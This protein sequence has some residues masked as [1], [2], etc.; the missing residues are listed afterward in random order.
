MVKS[1]KKKHCIRI[2]IK[3]KTTKYFR[4][5]T[6]KSELVLGRLLCLE[7]SSSKK[8]NLPV[9]NKC[10]E[11]GGDQQW[12]IKGSTSVK[13]YNMAAGTCLS[14]DDSHSNAPLDLSICSNDNLKSW[15]LVLF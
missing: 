11:S 2:K 15:D 5:E 6:D 9:L 8:A 12:K 14:V 7:A 3:K 13:I 4:F 10:H 1:I